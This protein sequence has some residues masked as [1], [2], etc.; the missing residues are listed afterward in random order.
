MKEFSAIMHV[1]KNST[2]LKIFKIHLS[3]GISAPIS[4]CCGCPVAVSKG[5]FVRFPVFLRLALLFSPSPFAI[6]FS[7]DLSDQN[8]RR[9]K[10]GEKFLFTEM[11]VK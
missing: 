8:S 5:D 7:A 11:A 10:E 2:I 1:S 3:Y 4:A 9:R 6:A